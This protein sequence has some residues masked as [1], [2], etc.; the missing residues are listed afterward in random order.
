V[1]WTTPCEIATRSTTWYVQRLYALVAV[2][3]LFLKV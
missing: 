2:V 1:T 3:G